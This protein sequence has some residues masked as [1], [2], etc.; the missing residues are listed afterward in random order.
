M[1]KTRFVL[2]AF[3][4]VLAQVVWS[5]PISVSGTVSDENG[6]TLPGVNVIEEG[7]SNGVS[8]DIDGNYQI[9][10]SSDA[11]L[12]FSYVGFIAQVIPVSGREVINVTLLEDL[13][14]L[15][16]VV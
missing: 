4:F 2:L 13:Q 15:E 14:D 12:V 8:T 7:T 1:I 5:Q 6:I 10:V 3:F 11:T 9:N 16:E